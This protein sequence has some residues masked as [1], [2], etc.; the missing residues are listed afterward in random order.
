M[1]DLR[2]RAKER[3]TLRSKVKRAR[4]AFWTK[5]VRNAKSD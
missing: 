4:A 1:V 2:G 3:R 5:A